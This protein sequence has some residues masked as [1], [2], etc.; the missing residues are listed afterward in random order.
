M[1]VVVTFVCLLLFIILVCSFII[2]VSIILFV[3]MLPFLHRFG[4]I[5]RMEEKD[6]VKE[7]MIKRKEEDSGHA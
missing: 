1:D 7:E 6:E 3:L 2:P 5:E 4:I